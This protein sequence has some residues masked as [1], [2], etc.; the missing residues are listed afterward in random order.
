MVVRVTRVLLSYAMLQ[1][2][3]ALAAGRFATETDDGA[4]ALV[5]ARV[6]EAKGT[7]LHGP[8]KL[9]PHNEEVCID[10]DVDGYEYCFV[11]AR[12]CISPTALQTHCCVMKSDAP[13]ASRS[14]TNCVNVAYAEGGTDVDF[15]FRAALLKASTGANAKLEVA[16]VSSIYLSPVQRG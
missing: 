15:N 4:P 6:K 14:Y 7:V 10:E 12:G 11:D 2:D 13:T 8:I 3:H 16:K 1:I 5:G 9:Q